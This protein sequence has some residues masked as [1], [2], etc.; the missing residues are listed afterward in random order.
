MRAQC[1]AAALPNPLSLGRESRLHRHIFEYVIST[2]LAGQFRVL[3]GPQP[4]V[5]PRYD[6]EVYF[7]GPEIDEPKTNEGAVGAFAG[8]M[9][10][11]GKSILSRTANATYATVDYTYALARAAVYGQ[12]KEDTHQLKKRPLSTSTQHHAPLFVTN[13]SRSVFAHMDADG[14]GLVTRA[15]FEATMLRGLTAVSGDGGHAGMRDA[16]VAAISVLG[17][18]LDGSDAGVDLSSFLEFMKRIV[19]IKLRLD[20]PMEPP[21]KTDSL[22]PSVKNNIQEPTTSMTTASDI[23][24]PARHSAAHQTHPAATSTVSA[25][26]RG[27]RLGELVAM[28]KLLPIVRILERAIVLKTK[29]QFGVSNT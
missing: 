2:E 14:D 27:R 12:E 28:V 23:H 16:Q 4:R 18:H 7:P 29:S 1:P 9:F 11:F 19:D 8:S 15:E 26:T 10:D 25:S 17:N 5:F 13:F 22:N 24:T 20:R 21:K 3:T 6:S